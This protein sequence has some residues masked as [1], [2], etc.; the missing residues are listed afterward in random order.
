MSIS[1]P[2]EALR[3]VVA[4]AIVSHISAAERDT[5]M[6][7]AVKYLLEPTRGQYGAVN[8]SP[9]QDA[10]NRAADQIAREEARKML[11]SDDSFRVR[12]AAI[13][14]DATTLA[15]ETKRDETVQRIATAIG[16]AWEPDR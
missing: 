16:R 8:A 11:E 4:A 9:I 10:F 15:F 7:A 6:A 5:I 1:I 13:I 12:L 14:K 2:P 3:E